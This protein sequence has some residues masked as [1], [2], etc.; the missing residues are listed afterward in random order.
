MTWS[1]PW[2]A[3]SRHPVFSRQQP[4]GG[5]WSRASTVF[6]RRFCALAARNPEYSSDAE[7]TPRIMSDTLSINADPLLNE[8]QVAELTGMSARSLQSW[9]L[10]GGGPA[11]VKLGRA[12]RYRRADV[13][14]WVESTL[15]TSTSH[16]VE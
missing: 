14:A 13:T 12:V 5:K 7:G 15:R 9:R 10:R 3:P 16:Q 1:T 4:L 2:S 11:F 6:L 8:R